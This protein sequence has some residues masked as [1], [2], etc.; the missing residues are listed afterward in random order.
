M[1][2]AIRA[3]RRFAAA[4]VWA[5]YIVASTNNATTDAELDQ[6]I[7]ENA[8]SFFHPVGT[9]GMSPRGAGYGVVD[10]DLRVKGVRGVRVVDASVLPIVPAAHTQAATYVFAERASGLIKES[11]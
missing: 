9:C 3:A 10:P 2:E 8:S 6:F 11:W 1:R 5:G 7:R 4:P